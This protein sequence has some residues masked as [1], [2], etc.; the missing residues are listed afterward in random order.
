MFNYTPFKP[1]SSTATRVNSHAAGTLQRVMARPLKLVF[2][3]SALIAA[4]VVGGFLGAAFG[5]WAAALWDAAVVVGSVFAIRRW[6]L[7]ER[8]SRTAA[9]EA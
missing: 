2:G 8:R 6:A 7:R 5:M 1:R 4:I 3:F 9:H